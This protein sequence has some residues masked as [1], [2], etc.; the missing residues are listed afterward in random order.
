MPLELAK[1]RVQASGAV[2]ASRMDLVTIIADITRREGLAGL[3]KGS[4]PTILATVPSAAI[5][6]ALY[7]PSREHLEPVCGQPASTG[8]AAAFAGGVTL[9]STSPLWYLKTRQQLLETS[10]PECSRDTYR[11]FGFRGFFCGLQVS[12]VGSLEFAIQFLIYERL[13]T[14]LI[15]ESSD[16][17]RLLSCG[18]AGAASK[19]VATSI[20]YPHQVVRTRLRQHLD[21]Y[22]RSLPTFRTILREEGVRAFYRGLHV[23]LLL[24]VPNMAITLAVY[25]ILIDLYARYSSD[26]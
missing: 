25:E 26:L 16:T 18:L 3:Y 19:A 14:L 12:M 4:A 17:S 21:K 22:Q 6:F 15:D 23:S 20:A 5:F 2:L 8:L 1:V 24:Q 13:K 7:R 9:A 11:R 10:L